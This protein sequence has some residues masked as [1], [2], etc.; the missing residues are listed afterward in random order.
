MCRLLSLFP[1]AQ[2]VLSVCR[3]LSLFPGVGGV[4]SCL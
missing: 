1:G 2:S 4:L 3:L